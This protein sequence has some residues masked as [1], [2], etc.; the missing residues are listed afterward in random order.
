MNRHRNCTIHYGIIGRRDNKLRSNLQNFANWGKKSKT[1][2]INSSLKT[3]KEY[4]RGLL[5]S[6]GRLC[7][8]RLLGGARRFR[9]RGIQCVGPKCPSGLSDT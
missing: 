6:I 3:R 4:F 8:T 1:G 5:L 9:A 7:V 2:G